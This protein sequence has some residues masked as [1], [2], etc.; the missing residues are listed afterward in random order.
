V[1]PVKG[2]LMGTVVFGLIGALLG[3][4]FSTD[5]TVANIMKTI[6]NVF[7]NTF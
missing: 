3:A 1:E 2:L 4:L 6:A 5:G 7:V